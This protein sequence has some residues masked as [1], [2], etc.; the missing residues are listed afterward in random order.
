MDFPILRPSEIHRSSG[1]RYSTPHIIRSPFSNNRTQQLQQ[2]QGRHPQLS[3]GGGNGGSS[4]TPAFNTFNIYNGYTEDAEVLPFDDLQE[5]FEQDHIRPASYWGG[6]SASGN[7]ASAANYRGNSRTGMIDW[8]Y[9]QRPSSAILWTSANSPGLTSLGINF[10][11]EAR[12][13]YLESIR[14]FGYDYMKPPGIS[15]TMQDVLDE[16]EL[17]DEFGEEDGDFVDEDEMDNSA[18]NM[19]EDEEEFDE[20]ADDEEDADE[21][22]D[23]EHAQQERQQR[24]EPLDLD[25]PDEVNLDDEIAQASDFDYDDSEGGY[26]DQDFGDPFMV[27]EDYGAASDAE[28]EEG[29]SDAEVNTS[30]GA[31]PNTDEAIPEDLEYYSDMNENSG[32]D[33]TF[34]D[35]RHYQQQPSDAQPIFQPPRVRSRRSVSIMTPPPP[36]RYEE[37]SARS[38][39]WASSSSRRDSGASHNSSGNLSVTPA[40]T[41]SRRT[42]ARLSGRIVSSEFSE[43]A[44]QPASLLDDDNDGENDD[45]H[46]NN[47]VDGRVGRGRFLPEPLRRTRPEAPLPEVTISRV[48]LE[49]SP[50]PS[51]S[52]Q[53]PMPSGSLL[54]GNNMDYRQSLPVLVR[55]SGHN[56]NNND[57]KGEEDIDDESEME[58]DDD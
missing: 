5:Q 53:L 28:E 42:S 46:I 24:N 35:I 4:Y 23:P 12:N 30:T 52:S 34:A 6:R 10:D 47:L 41:S 13:N 51:R 11:E 18:E 40:G 50:L 43:Y 9:S 32:P 39:S 15:K 7:R 14:T 29:R 21:V 54:A 20:F 49:L 44:M 19:E 3:S 56:N 26:D 17:S 55:D 48:E 38:V 1:Q 16:D 45:S 33:D 37:G 2:Q 27:D 25:D 31:I 58:V 22:N 8:A 57:N 36:A